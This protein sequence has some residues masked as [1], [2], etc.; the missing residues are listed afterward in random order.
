MG[1]LIDQ[2]ND[3]KNNKKNQDKNTS[4]DDETKIILQSLFSSLIS[5]FIIYLFGI[6]TICIG[7]LPDEK[8]KKIF[9]KFTSVDEMLNTYPSCPEKTSRRRRNTHAHEHIHD[10]QTGGNKKIR[11]QA[12]GSESAINKYMEE[13]NKW[14]YC[15]GERFDDSFEQMERSHKE[16][17]KGLIPKFLQGFM[18]FRWKVSNSISKSFWYGPAKWL[19]TYFTYLGKLG[20]KLYRTKF[21]LDFQK[22]SLRTIEAAK[23]N[24]TGLGD[25]FRIVAGILVGMV[26][27]MVLMIGIFCLGFGSMGDTVF[28]GAL[29]S[30]N[31][32]KGWGSL[33]IFFN[34]IILFGILGLGFASTIG[35]FAMSLIGGLIFQKEVLGKL[36]FNNLLVY[37]VLFYLTFVS[38]VA[39]SNVS[40]TTWAITFVIPILAILAN[41]KKLMRMLPGKRKSQ[42]SA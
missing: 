10:N 34:P 29:H 33:G 7:A 41:Y 36:V 8:F 27:A 12:G 14:L 32:F 26:I 11:I 9:P 6:S 21:P 35:Y 38:R 16:E 17:K 23:T 22:L 20:E 37:F 30:E 13:L 19:V 15:G 4:T 25:N 40:D 28:K 1:R 5:A 31:L 24:K 3:E 39:A 2:K 18:I 42:S